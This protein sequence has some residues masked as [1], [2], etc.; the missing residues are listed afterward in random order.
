MRIYISADLPLPHCGIA[1]VRIVM[2]RVP[3][4]KGTMSSSPSLYRILRLPVTARRSDLL[5]YMHQGAHNNGSSESIQFL[6]SAKK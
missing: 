5:Q 4:V 2:A 3:H 1:A 6:A